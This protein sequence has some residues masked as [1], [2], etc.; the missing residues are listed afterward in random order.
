MVLHLMLV[1][2]HCPRPKIKIKKENYF[3]KIIR[4][5]VHNSLD[6]IGNSHPLFWGEVGVKVNVYLTFS[7]HAKKGVLHLLKVWTFKWL[8]VYK[9]SLL[10]QDD[11]VPQI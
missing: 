10:F 6:Q 4:W 11:I 7:R 2:D 3:K 1:L 8:K 5:A 9:L